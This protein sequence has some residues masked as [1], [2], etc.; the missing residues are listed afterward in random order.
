MLV[1][2]RWSACDIRT[3][4]RLVVLC[5]WESVDFSQTA[6]VSA[7]LS[8]SH[9][10]RHKN[11]HSSQQKRRPLLVQLQAQFTNNSQ[12]APV[13]YGIYVT[14]AF[15]LLGVFEHDDFIRPPRE[16]SGSPIFRGFTTEADLL[17]PDD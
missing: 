13:W 14:A 12:S 1:N 4:C 8:S 7:S 2:A 10:P 6:R 5:I 15:L 3:G 11:R 17:A 9:S 16:L